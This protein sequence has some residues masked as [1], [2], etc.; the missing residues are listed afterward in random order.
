MV[1]RDFEHFKSTYLNGI[2]SGLSTTTFQ[3]SVPVVNAYT[4]QYSN[5]VN[6]PLYNAETVSNET[7][8]IT[9]R[10]TNPNIFGLL[11]DSTTGRFTLLCNTS[12][13][14]NDPLA[15]GVVSFKHAN[16]NITS[17]HISVIWN[18]S[19]IGSK[20]A[21]MGVIIYTDTPFTATA[22]PPPQLTWEITVTKLA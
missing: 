14:G 6:N 20:F 1:R 2:P 18:G 7:Y 5:L 9:A 16:F 21:Y 15:L 13:S 4:I 10:L 22:I 8:L 12:P 19:N 17:N 3:Q 11:T